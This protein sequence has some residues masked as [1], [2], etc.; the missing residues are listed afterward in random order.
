MVILL[1]ENRHYLQYGLFA[2]LA[3][4]AWFRGEA[5][6]RQIGLIFVAAI[7]L[8]IIYRQFVP[9]TLSREIEVPYLMLDI[10]MFVAFSSVA[11]RANRIY[12][13]WIL[14][15]QL[16]AVLMHFQRGVLEEMAPLA[17]WVLIRLPSYLQMLAFAIGVWKQSRRKARGLQSRPWRLTSRP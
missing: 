15:A 3:I 5:P 6:E 17:Y 16:I 4:W 8:Q 7:A 11:L 14:A 9:Q 13:L 10:L 1:I 12:P 2:A